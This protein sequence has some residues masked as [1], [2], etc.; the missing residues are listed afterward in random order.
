[1]LGARI[2]VLWLGGVLPKY[3]PDLMPPPMK[4]E[5]FTSSMFKVCFRLLYDCTLYSMYAVYELKD[6]RLKHTL[7]R[8]LFH[9]FP[10]SVNKL[11]VFAGPRGKPP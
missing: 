11:G 9:V 7:S 4:N 10:L 3:N 1:M 6:T 8:V 5:S 2:P